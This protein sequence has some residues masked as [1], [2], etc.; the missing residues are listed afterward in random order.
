M[1]RLSSHTDTA[2]HTKTDIVTD[3][4]TDTAIDT[5]TETD[6]LSITLTSCDE[7]WGA[8]KLDNIRYSEQ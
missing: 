6:H 5:E 8:V 2:S 1:K 4:D 7:Q 3:T